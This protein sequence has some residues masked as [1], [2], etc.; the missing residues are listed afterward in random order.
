MIGSSSRMRAAPCL[1]SC[2]RCSVEQD[3]AAGGTGLFVALDKEYVTLVAPELK[4]RVRAYVRAHR[5][6]IERKLLAAAA[7]VQA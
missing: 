3:E 6:A 7:A 2:S 1:L 4:Q 5:D